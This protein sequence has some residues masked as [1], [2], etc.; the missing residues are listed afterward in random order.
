MDFGLI[1]TGLIAD[2]HAEAIRNISGCRVSAAWGRNF[3]RT[4]QFCSRFGGSPFR[5]AGDLFRSKEVEAVVICTPSGTHADLGI[6][7]ARNGKH[8][9]V[10]KPIDISLERADALISA[11]REAGVK[12]ATCFQR[13]CLDHVRQVK[14]MVD[15]GK[16]GRLLV[17][18]AFI[19]WYRKPGYYAGSWHGTKALD[20]G[21]ALINQGIHA[22]DWLLWIGGPVR[23][24]A[25]RTRTLLHKIEAEDT[26]LAVLEFSNGA[27]GLIEATTCVYPGFAMRLEITGEKGSITITPDAVEFAEITNIP[28]AIK[29]FHRA[30][31]DDGS[32]DPGNIGWETHRRLIEDFIISIRENRKPLVDGT[33]GRRSLELVC[34]VYESSA[35]QQWITLK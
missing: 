19:K 27:A 28:D 14:E 23:S 13:R 4:Q 29:L 11:C 6:Q 12:L 21:G 26:A 2:I 8:V 9:L 15:A 33:E 24:V 34:A 3:E 30:G 17:V 25:A 31:L 7:A 35:K 1:G 22:V 32:S 5:E 10:E 18:D 20:G 16:L